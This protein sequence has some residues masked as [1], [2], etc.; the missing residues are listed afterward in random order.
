MLKSIMILL[1]KKK[2]KK[3]KL[4][5]EQEKKKSPYPEMCASF[6]GRA[7]R[8]DPSN[9]CRVTSLQPRG[10]NLHLVRLFFTH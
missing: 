8:N 4:N 2:K 6:Y 1:L 3:K 9:A 7:Y 10:V 5:G